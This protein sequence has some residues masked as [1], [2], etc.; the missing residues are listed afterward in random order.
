VLIVLPVERIDAR[1]LERF[2]KPDEHH[3]R[4]A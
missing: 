4:V 3:C 2:G 1:Y